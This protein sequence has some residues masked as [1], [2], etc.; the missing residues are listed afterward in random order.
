MPYHAPPFPVSYAPSIRGV[1]PPSSPSSP[2]APL[3]PCPA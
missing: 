2:A 3:P 1:T